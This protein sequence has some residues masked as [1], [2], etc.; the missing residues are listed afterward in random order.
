MQMISQNGH[1]VNSTRVHLSERQGSGGAGEQRSRGAGEQRSGGAE[2]SRIQSHEELDVHRLAFEAAMRVLEVSKGFP[3]EETHS[4]QISFNL[5]LQ[6][7]RETANHR[8]VA[9]GQELFQLPFK[10][11]SGFPQRFQH[12]WQG[13]FLRSGEQVRPQ[14]EVQIVEVSSFF[15]EQQ[16]LYFLVNELLS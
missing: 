13:V 15:P 12:L 14:N 8:P 16:C 9:S 2:V 1:D 11:Y 5:P 6:G 10:V 3:R 7:C 4:L